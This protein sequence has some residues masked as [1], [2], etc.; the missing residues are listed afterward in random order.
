MMRDAPCRGGEDSNERLTPDAQPF[1]SGLGCVA[2]A[3]FCSSGNAA[4]TR[5]PYS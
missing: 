4:Y 2:P 3:N 1:V 5:R